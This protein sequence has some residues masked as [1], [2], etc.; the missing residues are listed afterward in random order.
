MAQI[1][2]YSRHYIHLNIQNNEFGDVYELTLD[3]N[4]YVRSSPED[5]LYQHVED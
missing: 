5:I 1:T 4:E 2:R 3:T